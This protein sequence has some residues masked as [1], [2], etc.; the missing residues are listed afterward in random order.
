MDI[1]FLLY[2]N[3][4][5][6][7]FIGPYQVFTLVP[8]A[9]IHL[10]AAEPGPLRT[11]AGVRM[12]A[13]R[14]LEEVPR[15]DIVVVPGSSDP[16]KTMGDERVLAWL[17]EM[18][19]STKWTTSVCTGALILGAAGLLQ[20]KRAT[21]HWTATEMLRQFGATPVAERVVFDGKLVIA[22]GVSAGIDMAL[23]LVAREFG[24]LVSQ[25]IQLGIEYD[26]APP[27]ATG[28]L[29]TASPALI[30]ASKALLQASLQR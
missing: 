9:R 6:L 23:T 16:S 4:T 1:A 15:A 14:R 22:A 7:D 29:R 25:S 11:D 20:G 13:D 24:E 26:P 3:M 19:R 30:E 21:T 5:S 28:S 12:H 10:V 17:R 27:F 2:E 8:G 18:D